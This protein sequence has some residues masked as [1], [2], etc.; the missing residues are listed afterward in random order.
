MEPFEVHSYTCA[1][2]NIH[3]KVDTPY[4]SKQSGSNWYGRIDQILKFH[5]KTE[6]VY[7]TFVTIKWWWEARDNE[8]KKFFDVPRRKLYKESIKADK[9]LADP[10]IFFSR[11]LD[12]PTVLKDD[13]QRNHDEEFYF[14]HP[15]SLTGELLYSK[16]C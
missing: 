13:V 6:N 2:T 10:A 16:F 5:F 4:V 7:T 11:I 14:L 9:Y 12:V 15:E 1:Q 8:K 3:L